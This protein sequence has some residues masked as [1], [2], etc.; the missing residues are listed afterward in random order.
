VADLVPDR[1]FQFQKRSQLFIRSHNQTFSVIA[2]RIS[3][4]D[5]S[6]VGINRCDI[7]PTPTGFA[8]IVRY[9]FPI[10]RNRKVFRRIVRYS[11]DFE[12]LENLET[13]AIKSRITIKGLHVERRDAE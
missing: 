4:E 3:N 2:V 13:L 7:T 6:P 12:T 9:Y 11:G 10:L 5:R 1:R 8:E